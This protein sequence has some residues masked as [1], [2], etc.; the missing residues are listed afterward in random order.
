MLHCMHIEAVG[1]CGSSPAQ[2]RYWVGSAYVR[3]DRCVE[4]ASMQIVSALQ[5]RRGRQSRNSGRARIE[6][7]PLP[8]PPPQAREQ[9]NRGIAALHEERRELMAV[10][11]VMS[12]AG[13]GNQ[14]GVAAG[15]RLHAN[16]AAESKFLDDFQAWPGIS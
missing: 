10:L 5:A 7:E 14:D 15:A 4:G 16:I 13:A 11:W 3:Q 6:P 8:P 9:V 12:A 2:A 1:P